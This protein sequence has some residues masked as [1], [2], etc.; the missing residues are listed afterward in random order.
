MSGRMRIWVSI[1]RGGY[2]CVKVIYHRCWKKKS[3]IEFD[4]V[5][6]TLY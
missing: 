6:S 3:L 4:E 5:P 1:G 2:D